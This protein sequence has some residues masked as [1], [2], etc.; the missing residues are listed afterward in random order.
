MN[1][2]FKTFCIMVIFTMFVDMT[3][4]SN[5]ITNRDGLWRVDSDSV[6]ISTSYSEKQP[7]KLNIQGTIEKAIE[8]ITGEQVDLTAS[9]RTDRGVHA[10]RTSC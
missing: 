3:A 5:N 2:L 6:T 10:L 8:K 9:G 7:G 4:L 1:F